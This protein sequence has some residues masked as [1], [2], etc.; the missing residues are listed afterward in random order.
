MEKIRRPKLKRVEDL[1]VV[2]VSERRGRAP[3]RRLRGGRRVS[4]RR[5]SSPTRAPAARPPRAC[6]GA[7]STSRRERLR[8]YEKGGKVNVLPLADE[9]RE[10][11]YSIGL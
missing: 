5:R 8:F 4:L 6:A 1:D 2:T 11:L 3:V 7:T 9:L 10:I